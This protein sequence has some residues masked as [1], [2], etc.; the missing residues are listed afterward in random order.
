MSIQGSL[1]SFPIPD[2][3][4]LLL[5]MKKTGVL[6]IVSETEERGFLFADGNIVNATTQGEANRL[7]SFLVRLGFLREGDLK[8]LFSDAPPGAYFGQR[9]LESGQI[10]QKQ[11][12]RAVKAQIVEILEEVVG[13]SEGAFHFEDTEL[14]FDVPDT[15]LVATQSVVL[16]IARKSDET[17]EAYKIF[18][19]GREIFE[20]SGRVD[21][22]ELTPA[23]HEVLNLVDGKHTVEDVINRCSLGPRQ[24][25]M[26]LNELLTRNVVGR[27]E[28]KTRGVAA[29][30]VPDIKNLPIAPDVAAKLF[31]IFNFSQGRA[32]ENRIQDILS[33]EPL[34]IAKLVKSLTLSNREL[35]RAELR[36]D[37]LI[38]RL[39]VFHIRRILIPEAARGFFFPQE[40][41]VSRSP[42][43]HSHMCALLCRKMA[44]EIRYPYPEEAYL[45]GLLHNLGA[46]LLL[47]H[48]PRRYQR[49]AL[50]STNHKRDIEEVEE[51]AFGISHSKLGGKFAD[52]WGFPMLLSLVIK[53]HHGAK[54]GQSPLLHMVRA[55][56]V[57]LQD[58]GYRVGHDGTTPEQLE[59][60][61]DRLNLRREQ[62]DA[63][64]R[65][66]RREAD[67]DRPRRR[68]QIV[69]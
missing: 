55:A 66:I 68:L 7:G 67:R 25:A 35:G 16:D 48:S 17:R 64:L 40:D 47:H 2:V 20:V 4:G 31:A 12:H 24:T 39:G 37:R 44:E 11:L 45:A 43:K 8:A 30:K 63:F 28:F 61:L 26:A 51:E 6:A 38:G 53:N 22:S 13:W 41:S 60:A 15:N 69:V 29:C 62:I 32:L 19:D 5:Q 33:K 52:K 9:I 46:F 27:A 54:S 58:R 65:K 3:F 18:P 36:I 42:W 34:L 59:R 10:S 57:V 1:K 23:H 14:P 50:E 49:A 56:N 21:S